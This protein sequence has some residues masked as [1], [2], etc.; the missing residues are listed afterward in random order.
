MAT[1][2]SFWQS[3]VDFFSSFLHPDNRSTPLDGR[4]VRLTIN[5]ND[6]P[7]RALTP[8]VLVVVFDPIWDRIDRAAA[9]ANA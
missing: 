7:V 9:A 2:K 5:N 6:D 1:P 8:R 3:L 4:R